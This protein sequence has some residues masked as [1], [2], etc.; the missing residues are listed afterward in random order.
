MRRK[1][2]LAHAH[3]LFGLSDNFHP[4]LASALYQT[5]EKKSS[6][7]NVDRK[8]AFCHLTDDR[9]ERGLK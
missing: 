5:T 6:N 8:I 2:N 3:N 1:K 9:R 4:F 7:A